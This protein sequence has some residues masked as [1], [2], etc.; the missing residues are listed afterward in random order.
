MTGKGPTFQ[1]VI[2]RLERFWAQ[3]GC[4]IWQPY[5]V[6]VG[7]GTMNPATVLRVLG[8]EP[9]RV[10][11]VEPSVRPA[12]GRYAENPNRWQQFYQYQVILKPDPGNPQELYLQSLEAIGV[13]IARHDVR[14]V[15]DNWASPALGAWGL[16]WEV[17]CDG[18]EISQY[19]Y[20]QQ[21][22]GYPCDPVSVELTYGLERIML[23][24]QGVPTFLDIAWDDAITYGDLLH[25][26]EVELCTYNFEVADVAGLSTL[27]GIYEKEAHTCFDRGLVIPAHDYVLKCSHTFNV[28]DARGAIGVTERAAYFARMRELFHRVAEVYVAQREAAGYP[29]VGKHGLWA[30]PAVPPVPDTAEPPQAEPRDFL[31]EIGSEELPHADLRS[32]LA[33]LRERVPAML[34]EARL[35]HGDVEVNGTPRRCAVL[36]RDLAPRQAD[37]ERVVKGPPAQAAFDREG[38]PTR[39]AE[40]FAKRYGLAAVDLEVRDVDGGRYVVAAVRD[41]GRPAIAVLAEMLPRLIGSITFGQSMRWNASQVTYSRPLRWYV[42][43]YG[44]QVVPFEY[45]GVVSGRVTRG[46]RAPGQ[47]SLTVEDA[48]AYRD[49]MAKAGIVLSEQE[50]LRTIRERAASLAATVGGTIAADDDLLAEVANL[51]EAPNPI[52]GRFSEEYLA[53]PREVLITVMRKHQRYFAIE[54]SGRLLPCFIAVRNGGSDGEELV[55][56]GN[57][58]V[59]RAR[60]ADAAFFYKQDLS[61]PLESFLPRLGTLT[62]QVQLGSM[63]DKTRRLERLA[64]LL[65]PYVG[66]TAE[67]DVLLRRA[68]R[69]C[70]ADLA[71]QMVVEFTSLQ[72]V[73]GGI[74]AGSQHEDAR[75]A[76]AIRE[77]YLPR[78]SGDASPS[79]RIG[80]ALG[81]ADRLDSVVG[82]LAVG[83]EPTGSA[84]PY[85]L[86]RA[87]AGIVQSL[88]Q[89]QVRLDLRQAVRLAA[90]G[91]PV[92]ADD[93]VQSRALGFV[94]QRLRVYLQEQGLRYDVVDAVIS[95]RGFDPYGAL[96]AAV[97]LQQWVARPDWMDTLNAYGRCRRIVRDLVQRFPLRPDELGEAASRDLYTAYC[98]A[99]AAITPASGVDEVLAQVKA[100]VPAINRFFT[101]VL[102]MA[103]DRS[104]REN[105]LALVQAVASLTDGVVDL[106]RLEGF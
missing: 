54:D 22:G 80:L 81:L 17:W 90:D 11:Y 4:I 14:F 96:L 19:T 84:D 69:L 10:A 42:A 34:A 30:A 45:A 31:L 36:V 86:R 93:Q 8:P 32:A 24:L 62:F 85:A 66:L 56:H 89:W 2:M 40:G 20:M 44:D 70:K 43:L 104:E 72:G 28:L 99:R 38:R 76:A 68:A 101:D 41:E 102:V 64:P 105:R 57:E 67:E 87:A 94:V 50:R 106:S 39:A 23:F 25:R 65:A 33:Q 51:V 91:L 58:A 27:F 82:L 59:L 71:T 35:T 47:E 88:L 12:D 79:G 7:A 74:Y 48:A 100:M 73:I 98:Q 92:P 77:H 1:E 15:E 61:R 26:Q 49:V 103:E 6:Q 53:L 46:F 18:Q 97:Q 63:L 78:F 3:Q 52:L 95:E 9:W 5:N 29:L 21:S 83:L 13:D 75:V 16:G 55:R 37:Q 60:F